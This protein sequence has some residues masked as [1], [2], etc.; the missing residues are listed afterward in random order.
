MRW[1]TLFKA[2]RE[3]YS[4]QGLHLA[5]LGLKPSPVGLSAR[6]A[7]LRAPMRRWRPRWRRW[8]L[9]ARQARR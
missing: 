5:S 8:C 6:R 1:G 9:A 3:A 7:R 2:S 4:C